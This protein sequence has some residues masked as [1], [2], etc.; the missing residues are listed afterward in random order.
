MS[1]KT[2]YRFLRSLKNLIIP[3]TAILLSNLFH[4]CKK[5]NDG[6]KKNNVKPSC[7]IGTVLVVRMGDRLNF[8]YNSDGK[9]GTVIAGSTVTT[10]DHSMNGTVVTTRDAGNFRDKTTVTLNDAGLATNVR[11]END[12]A[13]THWINYAYEYNGDE[14]ARSVATRSGNSDS[15]ITTYGWLNHNLVTLVSGTTATSFDYYSE[16]ATQTGDYL[17]FIQLLQG[18]DIYRTRNLLKSISGSGVIY[19]FTP[20][21]NISSATIGSGGDSTKFDYGYQCN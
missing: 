17:S 1:S 15:A 16:K 11:T 8:F 6:N 18:Y 13:G 4:G 12:T 21:G 2:P 3:A 9:L 5:N 10:Y 14:L 7:L 19:E 20:D